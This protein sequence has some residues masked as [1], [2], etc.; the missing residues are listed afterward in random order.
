MIWNVTSPTAL[1]YPSFVIKPNHFLPKP[2][3]PS[4]NPWN[5]NRVIKSVSHILPS[6][7]VF[8]TAFKVV[9]L[10][11]ML[12]THWK[13]YVPQLF[14]SFYPR[15]KLHTNFCSGKANWLL[16]YMRC[17]EICNLR[18]LFV[19]LQKLMDLSICW[20]WEI[21]EWRKVNFYIVE[22]N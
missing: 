8:I 14:L 5:P 19:K 2:R 15:E 1:N 21:P 11:L 18:F 9:F 7:F 13:T 6:H 20:G 22:M 3:I 16:K 12:S 17:D 10:I 4:H